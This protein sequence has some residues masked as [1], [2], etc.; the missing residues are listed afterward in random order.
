MNDSDKLNKVEQKTGKVLELTKDIEFQIDNIIL[1]Y[2]S[3]SK[4]G[5]TRDIILNS[6]IMPVGNKVK[7]LKTICHELQIKQDFQNLHKLINIRNIFAHGKPYFEDGDMIFKLPEIKSDGKI[8]ENELDKLHKEFIDL[9]NEQMQVLI[10]L[11]GKIK[12]K[13]SGGEECQEK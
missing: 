6:S 3:P 13:R 12:Q 9:F 1:D 11:H 4:L 2:L 5:F 10:K 8:L 7:I